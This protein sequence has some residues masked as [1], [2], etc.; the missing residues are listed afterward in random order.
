MH[1][2]RRQPIPFLICLAAL[3]LPAAWTLA[4]DAELPAKRRNPCSCVASK[5]G[6][7]VFTANRHSGSISVVDVSERSVVQEFDVGGR[8]SDLCLFE[9]GDLLA[10]TDEAQSRVV[11]LSW[12]GH[13]LAWEAQVSLPASPASVLPLPGGTTCSVA[14]LWG[15]ELTFVEVHSTAGADRRT[16]VVSERIATPFSPREQLV[17]ADGRTLIAADAF[18]GNLGIVDLPN[19]RLDCVRKV[20]G[21]N[22]RGMA[23][24]AD[25]RKLLLSHQIL[26]SL[27]QTSDNDVH[28]GILMSNVLRWLDL[29]H[30][31]SDDAPLLEDS[32][33]HSAGDSNGA[34]GDPA[35]LV[36]LGDGRVAWAL[37]GVGEL[38]TGREEDFNFQ[39]VPVGK[40]PVDVVVLDSSKNVCLVDPFRDTVVV[41][42]LDRVVVDA[43]IPLGPSRPIEP[44]EAGEHLFYDAGLSLDGW[45]SCHSCHTDGHTN[46]LL[47]DNLADG[48][49]GAAKRVPSLFGVSETGPW[50]WNGRTT[51][52]EEQV[53][54]SITTTMRGEDPSPEA[55]QALVA[56][57]Q[58]LSTPPIVSPR[59]QAS[60][61][62]ERGRRLFESLG[63][64]NC[65]EPP[66]YTTP[67]VYDVGI[68]D[69]NGLRDFNPPSL[70]GAGLGG[71]YLHDA[72]ATTLDDV[73]LRH[74]HGLSEPLSG[75][76][77]SD[78]VEFVRQL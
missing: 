69:W 38:A 40:R 78:L 33:V 21:H 39:R 17:L 73:F 71:P 60:E 59:G 18:G 24:S 2:A 22:I 45:M 15:R 23:Q 50:G 51:V 64:S 58:S 72:R 5:D 46:G 30:V 14:S 76:E 3:V 74:G 10:V 1:L 37:S 8:L 70:R 35:A 43:V 77:L 7:W 65:H 25:G 41:A 55:V 48:S 36:V 61:A 53:V 28:W 9:S 27:A 42:D 54:R 6:E 13:R 26:N 32:H 57:L 20:P 67:G 29:R 4:G 16:A 34:G 62:R 31:L 47:A 68:V 19:R 75:E 44:I 66:T 11:F 52:L 63:C 49:F 56:F 12:T